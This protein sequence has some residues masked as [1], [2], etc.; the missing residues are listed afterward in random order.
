MFQRKFAH[1]NRLQRPAGE[2]D[3]STGGGAVDRGDNFTPT[4]D[5]DDLDTKPAKAT[6]APKAAPTSADPD[7][8]DPD[9]ADPDAA[10]PDAADAGEDG[11]PKRK[12]E[13]RI[14]LSR[15][16]KI[17]EKE[18]ERREALEAQLA[19]FQKGSEVAKT[20]RELTEVENKLL[21][22]EDKHTE[23]LADGDVDKAKALMRQIR[24]LDRELADARAD[25][26]AAEAEARA[27]EQARYDIVLERIES[28]FPQLNPD[29][30]D[31]DKD[32]EQDV[33][34]LKV[35]YQRRGMTPA[36]ALQKAVKKLLGAETRQQEQATE[37]APRVDAAAV[38][39]QRKKQ[40]VEKTADAVRRTPPATSRVGKDSD[41]AGGSLRAEDVLK[42]S[43]DDFMKLDEAELKRL[44][45]DEI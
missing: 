34:D 1:L 39:A 33:V 5:D 13:P 23:A 11:K 44:R 3:L 22:L 30:D 32:L 12:S 26:R 19:Q 24:A 15:H 35:T 42:M 31:Y 20:N 6:K 25:A 16:E 21:D 41:A 18:R 7:V 10:D 8:T 37:V 36:Q 17:L 14:P 27:V 4:V 40:A 28:S 2:D 38:A 29:H 43:Q 45:G 9:A